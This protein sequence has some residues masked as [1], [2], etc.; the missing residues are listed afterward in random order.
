MARSKFYSG[1]G[2]DVIL[3]AQNSEIRERL[4]GKTLD[5][6]GWTEELGDGDFKFVRS[7]NPKNKQEIWSVRLTLGDVK[8]LV[9][10]SR[11]F[12]MNKTKDP[13]WLLKCEFRGGFL[14][15]KDDNGA[16]KYDEKGAIVLDTTKPYL[17]FGAPSGIVIQ[18]EVD[19]FAELSEAE[20]AKIKEGA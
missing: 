14:S 20:L 3:A 4:Q 5:Q 16:P 2:A 11:N 18:E 10:L 6:V 1:K 17:S 7:E 8:V 12:D 9:P 13:N 19:P 15:V